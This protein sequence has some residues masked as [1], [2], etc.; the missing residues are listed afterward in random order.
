MGWIDRHYSQRQAE[1]PDILPHQPDTEYGN[2]SNEELQ[3]S[4]IELEE[5]VIDLSM[6]CSINKARTQDVLN[7]AGIVTKM[8]ESLQA[9][10]NLLD[11]LR[12]EKQ[13]R[14]EISTDLIINDW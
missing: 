1:H 10:R 5:Q 4:I 14:K 8:D 7:S 3:K 2:V 11:S 13:L 12:R 6:Y 9:L